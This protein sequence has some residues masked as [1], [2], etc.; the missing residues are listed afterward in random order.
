MKVVVCFQ[1]GRAGGDL[2]WGEKWVGQYFAC[3]L[4]VRWFREHHLLRRHGFARHIS[5]K[6]VE[7]ADVPGQG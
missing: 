3:R 4:T 6:V 7:D 2:D 5:K 1:E